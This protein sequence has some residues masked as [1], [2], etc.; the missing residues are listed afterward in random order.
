MTKRIFVVGCGHT[1]TSLVSIMLG[2]HPQIYAIPYETGAFLRD[3]SLAEARQI[4]DAATAAC[5]KPDAAYICEKTPAHV[6][7]LDNIL[8]VYPEARFIVTTR[9]PRDVIASIKRRN[10]TLE[11]GISR[12]QLGNTAAVDAAARPNSFSLRYEALIAEPEKTLASLCRW[13]GIAFDPGMLEYWKDERDWFGIS[14]RRDTDGKRGPNHVIR[15]NW[16]IH[17][18]L[19]TD[20]IGVWRRELSAA[21]IEIVE[22]AIR[23]GEHHDRENTST[24]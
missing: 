23:S 11:N 18:P 13:L 7:C 1:G 22:R 21:E 5:D 2:A 3:R 14:E 8:A 12:W 15:R 17:Q 9:D 19:M 6:H 10:G 20:R 4:I 16:Q 24:V